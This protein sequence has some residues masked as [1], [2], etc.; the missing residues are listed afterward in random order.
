[1]KFYT[2]RFSYTFSVEAESKE[3][4]EA[5]AITEWSSLT[6]LPVETN[7]EVWEIEGQESNFIKY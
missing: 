7:I 3:H 2:V 4:A 1:M 6:P 5:K